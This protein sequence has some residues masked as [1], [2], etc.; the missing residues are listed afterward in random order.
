MQIQ[1]RPGG[2]E[3]QIVRLSGG[4]VGQA[5]WDIGAGNAVN[6]EPACSDHSVGFLS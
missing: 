2:E 6:R 3:S 5:A 4:E 1:E